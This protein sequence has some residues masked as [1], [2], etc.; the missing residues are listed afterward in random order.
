MFGGVDETTGRV[1]MHFPFESVRLIFIDDDNDD[2]DDDP[3]NHNN[4]NNKY[5]LKKGNLYMDGK[6]TDY[7]QFEEYTMITN[8]LEEGLQPQWESLDN[9]NKNLLCNC[10]CNNCNGCVG[11]QQDLLLPHAK[12]LLP[13]DSNVYK[14]IVAEISDAHSM[15]CGLFFC[16]HHEDVAHPTAKAV[17][18]GGTT[19]GA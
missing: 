15:P 4:N 13:V 1:Q 12:Y 18:G 11:K 7:D 10:Q 8:A 14:Q 6:M 16:G 17:G 5:N 19:G 2:D 3:E 9:N